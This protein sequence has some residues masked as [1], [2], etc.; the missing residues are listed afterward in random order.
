[1]ALSYT[2]VLFD[3]VGDLYPRKEETHKS[4]TIAVSIAEKL[5]KENPSKVVY[6][7]FYRSTD[8]QHGF[9][10]RDGAGMTGRSWTTT[11]VAE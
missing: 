6:I 7:N 2:V 11:K 4:K 5:A 10:N 3:E 9:I 8:G 1:M